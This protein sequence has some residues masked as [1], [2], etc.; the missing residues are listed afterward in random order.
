M[1]VCGV[2]FSVVSDGVPDA[3]PDTGQMIVQDDSDSGDMA[4][5]AMNDPVAAMQRSHK[6]G[7][8]NGL[9]MPRLSC[10]SSAAF[11]RK[12][13]GD[14]AVS[15]MSS[16]VETDRQTVTPNSD[17][18]QFETESEA[19]GMVITEKT[20][21]QAVQKSMDNCSGGCAQGAVLDLE[22]VKLE[23]GI[24][25]GVKDTRRVQTDVESTGLRDA[26][27]AESSGFC[28]P[29]STPSG[30]VPSTRSLSPPRPQHGRCACHGKSARRDKTKV[31]QAEGLSGTKETEHP[32]Y[33]VP[34][35]DGFKLGND[36]KAEAHDVRRD[37]AVQNAVSVCGGP[38]LRNEVEA[39]AQ[40]AD[41]VGTVEI[42]RRRYAAGQAA[43]RQ[44]RPTSPIR[45]ATAL[46][47]DLAVKM[48]EK[49]E[50]TTHFTNAVR[51]EGVPESSTCV[52]ALRV[53]QV[54]GFSR[55][56]EIERPRYGGITPGANAEIP[57][58]RQMA[59]QEAG[60][61]KAEVVDWIQTVSGFSK[62]D[63]SI[64]EWLHD[65]RVLCA[66]INA[67]RPGAIPKVNE[68]TSAFDQKE[69]ITYFWSAARDMGVL[70]SSMCGTPALGEE[71]IGSVVQRIYA[72]GGAVQVNVPGSMG[73][74]QEAALKAAG[75]VGAPESSMCGMPDLYEETNR[76]TGD[77]FL[78][79]D[80]PNPGNEVE[81]ETHG[82]KDGQ[83][84]GLSR[85]TEV[86]QQT[87]G[88]VAGRQAQPKSPCPA[89]AGVDA[90]WAVSTRWADIS[91]SVCADGQ[92]AAAES[93]SD[94]ENGF[95]VA[96]PKRKSSW[97]AQRMRTESGAIRTKPPSD[98]AATARRMAG[99]WADLICNDEDHRAQQL[100]A[101][102]SE[103]PDVDQETLG[104]ALVDSVRQMARGVPRRTA[105][106]DRGWKEF[107]DWYSKS[108][109]SDP[110][111][112]QASKR[113]KTGSSRKKRRP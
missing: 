40:S 28:A 98:E 60:S 74:S 94:G 102:V 61:L 97:L 100:L 25:A 103:H 35:F 72:L 76:A 16:D 99:L 20:D 9:P 36:V 5:D 85:T 51:D 62:G 50:N 32:R 47:A 63:A 15:A 54:A 79:C 3:P 24:E 55:T 27:L 64:A 21:G 48:A 19:E 105:S 93:A 113:E 86:E 57:F 106:I 52:G 39:E 109:V 90:G 33:A 23:A 75:G 82:D 43:G 108:G 6:D 12:S 18:L 59:G 111:P 69:S 26:F 11:S 4:A 110:L 42:E 38:K 84:A 70:E 80:G 17:V 96:N 7:T 78:E 58:V 41:R 104:G 8:E 73:P 95:L 87:A 53:D 13:C 89:F 46:D 34:E 56:M 29:S 68:P 71:N 22:D 107:R 10:Q 77:A 88:Q 14:S 91:D 67:I 37:H 45:F 66:L 31:D 83:S 2:H 92:S 112:R 65:G 49:A 101:A 44:V 1:N 30:Q 81:A